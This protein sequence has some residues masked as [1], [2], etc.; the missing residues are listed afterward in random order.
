MSAIFLVRPPRVALEK[1]QALRST[2]TREP[3]RRSSSRPRTMVWTAQTST[4]GPPLVVE[5]GDI[6]LGLYGEDS[7]WPLRVQTDGRAARLGPTVEVVFF[8]NTQIDRWA[9]NKLRPFSDLHS[10]P[11][12]SMPKRCAAPGC[13]RRAHR[14]GCAR[15][16]DASRPPD[17]YYPRIIL[18]YACLSHAARRSRRPS[19]RRASG[20]QPPRRLPLPHLAPTACRPS[21]LARASFPH[22]LC[23]QGRR[24]WRRSGATAA[25]ARS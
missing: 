14:V 20:S 13:Q 12:R 25:R 9:R 22:A 18:S 17:G 2:S 4:L 10:I 7:W 19:R 8:G 5:H 11:S 24:G 21:R 6:C 3:H 1:E 15:V 16:R 23:G